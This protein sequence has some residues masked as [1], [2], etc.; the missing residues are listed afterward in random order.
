MDQNSTKIGLGVVLLLVST[1]LILGTGIQNVSLPTVAGS[2]AA[3]G[4]A[5]G[6]LLVGT[7][8]DGQPV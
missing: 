4:L 8:G 5:A 7:A 2:L 3:L 1:V 6:A